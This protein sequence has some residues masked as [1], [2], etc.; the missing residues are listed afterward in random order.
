MVAVFSQKNEICVAIAWEKS[1]AGHGNSDS[2]RK[3]DCEACS[4]R[5]LSAE[6]ELRRARLENESL[7][8]NVNEYKVCVRSTHT[9]FVLH[10][11]E[12]G[13]GRS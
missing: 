13:G 7:M 2:L 5:I 8:S 10:R 4:T 11:E 6:E 3:R 1:V 9:N 12:V